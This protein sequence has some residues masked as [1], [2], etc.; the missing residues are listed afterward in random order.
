VDHKI[1]LEKLALLGI[2]GNI[3][4]WIRSFLNSRYQYVLVNGFL[5]QPSL[6]KS[7]VPQGSVIGPLLFLIM[8]RDIDAELANSFLSSFADDIRTL[9]GISSIRDASLLQTD[10]DHIYKWSEDNNMT[11][12]NKKLEVLRYGNN[13]EIK[14]QTSYHC[15]DDSVMPEN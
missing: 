5:S 8:I 4:K 10:L 1:I 14:L 6:V 15:P 7:G 13:Q 9:S 11:F 3:L 2:G 12:N